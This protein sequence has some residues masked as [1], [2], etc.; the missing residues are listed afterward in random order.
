MSPLRERPKFFI[1]FYYQLNFTKYLEQQIRL[2]FS[3]SKTAFI[4][5]VKNKLVN[6][7]Y[8]KSC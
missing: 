3:I 5:L 1:I 4:I 8:D 6:I 2:Y 7:G